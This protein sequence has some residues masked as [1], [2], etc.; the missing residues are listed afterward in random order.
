MLKYSDKFF[1]RIK[2]QFL[3]VILFISFSTLSFGQ[4]KPDL[5]YPTTNCFFYKPTLNFTWNAFTG[6][7]SYE[8]IV[9]T[10]NSFSSIYFSQSGITN[11]N[12]TLSN[13]PSNTKYYWKIRANL[14]G[15]L[16]LWSNYR[17]F[18]IFNPNDVAGTLIWYAS[19]SGVVKNISNEIDT[20][21]D[22]SGNNNNA[23]Q[24]VASK[25][26][27]FVDT[28]KF[29]K[30]VIRFDGVD[31]FMN[32]NEITNIRSCFFI[33]K[34][35]TGSQNYTPML[36]HSV[37][38]DFHGG[39]GTL[40]F[41]AQP[42]VANIINGQGY[43]NS[44]ALTPALMVK[45]LSYSIISLILIGDDRAQYITNGTSEGIPD[46]FWHGDFAEI[47]LYN[48]PLASNERIKVEE[49]LHQKY[50]PPVNL[51]AD[52]LINVFC[53]TT[54]DAG[55]RF[56]SYIWST[57]ET[58]QTISVLQSGNYSVT[59][60]DLFGHTSIDTVKIYFPVIELHDTL[61]CSGSSVTLDPGISGSYNYE[62]STTETTA[63]INVNTPG[64]YWVKMTSLGNC[65][66]YSDTILVSEDY[67]PNIVSLGNDTSLCFGNTIQLVNGNIEAVSYLWS[68]LETVPVIAISSSGNYSV[69]TTDMFGCSGKDTINVSIAGVAPIADFTSD[70]GCSGDSSY[71]TDIT[72]PNG[73]II[74]N[75]LWDFG[76]GY[77]STQQNP[78]HVYQN[79]GNYLITFSVFTLSGC[80]NYKTSLI[81]IHQR[82][83]VAFNYQGGCFPFPVS[84][85]DVSSAAPGDSIVSWEWN[86]GDPASG[87]NLSVL[88]NPSHVFSNTGTF[89][90]T[91]TLF[92]QLGCNTTYTLPLNVVSNA[93][94]PNQFSLISPSDNIYYYG[95]SL[96]FTWNN[97]L[98]AAS[99]RLVMASDV[100]FN[101]IVFTSPF[102]Q[103]TTYTINNLPS[104]SLLFW[105]VEAFNICN[106]STL[107]NTC[108]IKRFNNQIFTWMCFVANVR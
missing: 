39:L 38:Y 53:D 9:A 56:S 105:R 74:T 98:S 15:P 69:T 59:A 6:A 41:H 16:S 52:I 73:N 86:F 102:L 67:Y 1:F 82:P 81:I 10:D 5:I 50:F 30:P 7:T 18:T 66:K 90:I 62:W 83:N 44:V 29:S 22:L 108:L 45:P 101:N 65:I 70:L 75:W 92:T 26:P 57:G 49:Y 19:D 89:N 33:V 37:Y 79:P 23:L 21:T 8:I 54:L 40:L 12:Y 24:N 48:Q 85:T 55:G 104:D 63:T 64:N 20:W 2:K 43:F 13:I 31:D 94:V 34:N 93:P 14:G 4:A 91:H 17:E 61:F 97:S 80:N 72:T 51:G 35:A 87:N 95:N 3:F 25:K 77:T 100:Q 28:A 58:T 84:F 47:I 46:A 106:D 11:T 42:Y 60:T 68:T 71:F 88:Q 27:L 107:S 103:S 36:G 32:F 78:F 76:D 99:Y 96:N